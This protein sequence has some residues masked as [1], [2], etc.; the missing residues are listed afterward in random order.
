MV[1]AAR[2]AIRVAK[3]G[4]LEYPRGHEPRVSQGEVL[5]RIAGDENRAVPAG[6][7]VQE[8]QG[9]GES[10]EELIAS[11]EVLAEP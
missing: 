10:N 1:L 8:Q 6:G 9:A 4:P 7:Q 11:G 3:R 2:G 5:A